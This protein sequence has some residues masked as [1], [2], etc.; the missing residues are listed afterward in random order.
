MIKF[1]DKID[2]ICFPIFNNRIKNNFFDWF[3]PKYTNLG[4]L[5]FIIS[6]TA[7]LI[8]FGNTDI[9]YLGVQMGFALAI[10]QGI[11]YPM[12]SIIKRERPYNVIEDLNTFGFIMKDYSF[13]SGH[14]SASFTLATVMALNYPGLG[15]IA[16]IMAGLVA[17]SRM[18]I[19]VHYPTD[20]L[21]GIIIGIGSSF[22]VYIFLLDYVREFI[23]IFF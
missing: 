15:L 3:L 23:N 21:A 22:I 4:G 10:S 5:F 19:G 2:E 14:S 18:Y 9:R 6:L 12:K 20:V 13:P 16:I 11:T 7:I 1:F 8:I 17:I